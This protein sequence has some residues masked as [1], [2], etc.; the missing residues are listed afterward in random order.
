M[1][2]SKNWEIRDFERIPW[3][4]SA[5]VVEIQRSDKLSKQSTSQNMLN[6]IENNKGFEGPLSCGKLECIGSGLPKR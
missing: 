2:D 4:F 5:A 3:Y 6:L 1:H